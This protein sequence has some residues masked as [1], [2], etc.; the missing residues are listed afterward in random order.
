[1]VLQRAYDTLRQMRGNIGDYIFVGMEIFPYSDDDVHE[2]GY[3]YYIEF[4]FHNNNYDINLNCIIVPCS[5][6]FAKK[7]ASYCICKESTWNT[8]GICDEGY[9]KVSFDYWMQIGALEGY[10]EGE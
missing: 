1:M 9:S 10:S 7:W 8:F 6:W 5:K 4:Y 3:D 2:E